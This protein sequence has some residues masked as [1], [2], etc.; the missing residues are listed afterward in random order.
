M[1]SD[2]D[3]KRSFLRWERL[4]CKVVKAR[5]APVEWSAASGPQVTAEP[6]RLICPGATHVKVGA[7]IR[8]LLRQPAGSDAEHKVAA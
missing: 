7:D 6:Y 4:E 8:K 5:E 3:W 1:P 2:E